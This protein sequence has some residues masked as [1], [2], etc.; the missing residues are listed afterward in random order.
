M[1]DIMP[2]VIEL[3]PGGTFGPEA[4]SQTEQE[5]IFQEAEPSRCIRNVTL[6]TL[7]VFLPD[8]AVATGTGV[9]VC[10]GGGH[11][12]LMI[13]REGYDVARWLNEHGIAAFVLKYRVIATPKRDEEFIATMTQAVDYERALELTR[14]H[15]PLSIE[16]GRQAMRLVRQHAAEWGV[17]PERVGIM[18]FSAGG[19]VTAGVATQYDAESRPAFAAPI[20]GALWET[21][22]VPADAPPLFIALSHDDLIA[23]DPA[24]RLYTAWQAAGHTAELHIY[25]RGGHGYGMRKQ[26]IPADRW[27]EHFYAWLRGERLVEAIR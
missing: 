3:W 2:E 26:G 18:G 24:I 5:Y 13:D 1:E 20:Y 25:A 10:P 22:D 27:I 19:H 11:H 4:S 23:V 14:P 12:I 17:A 8:P 6:P 9:V 15:S 16:D 7:T 21:I